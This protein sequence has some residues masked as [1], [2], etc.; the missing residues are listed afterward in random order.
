MREKNTIFGNG[1]FY[2]S[3][4]AIA[5]PIMLQQLIQNMVSLIDN[6]MVSGLGDVSMSGVNVAGQVLFVF[7]VFTNT[8]CMTGGIFLTQFFGAKD[9][10]GMQQ[11][12]IFKL[13]AGLVALIPYLMVCLIYPREILS[14][15]VIGNTQAPLILDEAVKYIRIMSVV[16]IPMTISVS[17][18]SSLRDMGQ[19]KIPLAVTVIATLTN[20][21]FNYLL[22][23]GNLGF[24]ALG[25][26]GA[27]YATVIARSLEFI[28][29][30]V[31]YFRSR[32]DFAIRFDRDFMV[33]GR[34]FKEI[35]KK[36]AL[37][38][39]C[40]MTWVLSETLTTAIYNGR[41][42]ADVVSGMASSFAIANLFFVAF[43]GI[44]SA[45][46]VIIGK[47]LGEG[48]LEKA[49]REKTWLLSGAI[50]F[51]VAMT[52]VGFATTLIIPVVFGKLSPSAIAI[53]RSMVILMAFFMP[54][55]VLVNAQQAIARSGGDTKMGAYA[56]AGITIA[57]MLPMLFLLAR[58]TD[59][60]PVQMYLCVKLLDIVRT[61]IFHFWLKKERW[62][63]NLA[64][65]HQSEPLVQK[66]L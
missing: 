31:I 1:Q 9:R 30:L 39:F 22:I 32:P 6:F 62:L 36:G 10:G 44:Y 24:P 8:I 28:I 57:V 17:I 21:V 35:L 54:V 29:F 47:T 59:I 27:A 4:L 25:V 48:N 7:M 52:F 60:G 38:L 53:S 46:T 3:V 43:G 40:E 14:L 50:V 11:A 13:L 45:T 19:V 64:G 37:M 2:K 12:F 18:A 41:G 58:Y 16:G 56:D 15:M 66:A 49:R 5:V 55:W 26:R 63:N 61:L 33:D 23:Y 42:G 34:L 65:E 20:T 51:G